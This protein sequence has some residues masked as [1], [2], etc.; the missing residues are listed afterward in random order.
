[1]RRA[2]GGLLLASVAA[3]QPA[4]LASIET[5]DPIDLSR[6]ATRRGDAAVLDGLASEDRAEVD[7]A[8][9]LAVELPEPEIAVPRLCALAV[10]RDPDLAPAAADAVAR[11][12]AGLDPVTLAEREA[13][14][15]FLDDVVQAAEALAGDDAAHPTHRTALERAAARVEALRSVL[16]S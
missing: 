3:A 10:G 11:V 1:V 2:L 7:A 15:A 9:A 8:V 5:R 14:I 13:S 4:S 12:L 6:E 16:G